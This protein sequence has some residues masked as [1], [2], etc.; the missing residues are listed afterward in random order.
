MAAD[1]NHNYENLQESYL[2]AETAKRVNAYSHSHP[3]AKLIRMG[4][5]DV[6]RPL[7]EAVVKALHR[8]SDEMG[9]AE[10]FRGYGPEQGYD[11]LREAVREY[12]RRF[13]VELA[14]EEIF[15][16]DGAKSDL[17]NILDIFSRSCRVLVTDPVYPVYVDTNLMDGREIL[18]ARAGEENGFLPMPEEG[19]EADLIYLCSPNNPT[20]A[21]YTREQLKE[22]V[23]FAN[24]RGSVIIFEAA[25]E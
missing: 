17:G 12:Y 7:P 21:V 19:M 22:W 14:A 9:K 1:I 4:I 23:D 11:F 10:T 3:E 16:S 6:T 8:A 2:F 5:G 20:G 25:Y 18:Y 24:V 13:G 15:I